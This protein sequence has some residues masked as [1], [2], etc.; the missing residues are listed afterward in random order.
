MEAVLSELEEVPPDQV[1]LEE[2]RLLADPLVVLL[3]L[4][5]ALADLLAGRLDLV[6]VLVVAARSRSEE[7]LF[8]EPLAEV[9]QQDQVHQA[10]LETC[11]S[12][13]TS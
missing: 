1:H 10:L 12:S 4:M 7:T 8:P 11:T 13:S 3:D 2:K 6:E 9:A 5:E